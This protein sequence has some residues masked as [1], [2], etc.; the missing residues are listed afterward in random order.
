MSFLSA[1]SFRF[2]LGFFGLLS[3]LFAPPWVPLLAMA[4]LALGFT[5]WEVPFIGL[6]ID[7]SWHVPTAAESWIGMIP[8]FTVAGVLLMWSFE[9]LRREFLVENTGLL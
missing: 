6:I 7:F 4:V 9:P 3:A 8:L 1:G 2:A 5:A